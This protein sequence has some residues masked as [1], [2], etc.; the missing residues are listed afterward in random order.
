ML[1]LT[2]NGI[3]DGMKINLTLQQLEGEGHLKILSN[4]ELV[5]RA[6][7]EAELFAGGEIPIQV[8]S[9]YSSTI[10]WKS[11]GLSLKLKVTHQAGEK[12]RLE[13]F[14]EVS[15]LD[16]SI[17]SI[18]IP[19]IQSNR[20]KTQVDVCMGTPLFLS[21]LLQKN[22]RETAKGLPFL[23]YLPVLGHLF[24]SSDYLEAKSEFIAILY[25]RAP[26]P[27][28]IPSQTVEY[29]MPRGMLPFPR[30]WIPPLEERRLKAELEY[31]WN[32]FN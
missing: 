10:Q 13:I 2:S 9:R 22:M 5:V 14:T 19:G 7:G 1:Q 30:N 24:G 27:M 31:P 15:H 4:P 32:V 23:R 29:I 17:S 8:Q 11:Y 18:A 16:A 28:P 26:I 6:P 12:L 20:M 21:G 25:P 3:R